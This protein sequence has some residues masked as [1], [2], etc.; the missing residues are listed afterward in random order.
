VA[1]AAIRTPAG[2]V[3]GNWLWPGARVTVDVPTV[4]QAPGVCSDP[5]CVPV[6][7]RTLYVKGKAPPV[8][9]I[10]AVVNPVIVIAFVAVTSNMIPLLELLSGGGETRV[11]ASAGATAQDKTE[12]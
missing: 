11:S 9:L 5:T 7:V 10:I 4:V 6:F 3:I 12:T 2:S 1:P 8:L